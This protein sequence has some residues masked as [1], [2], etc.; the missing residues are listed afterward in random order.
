MFVYPPSFIET[1]FFVG[2]L[3]LQAKGCLVAHSKA[4]PSLPF[5]FYISLLSVHLKIKTCIFGPDIMQVSPSMSITQGS[6]FGPH[7]KYFSIFLYFP[8]QYI[9]LCWL[10]RDFC[11]KTL[12]HGVVQ[13]ILTASFRL[14]PELQDTLLL[15][16]HTASCILTI[17][18]LDLYSRV[19]VYIK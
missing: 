19:S 12:Y 4:L 14:E 6:C 16:I 8:S 1:F 18:V 5:I 10:S 9:I 11:L 2:L 3:L 15:T 7:A 13:C 17:T